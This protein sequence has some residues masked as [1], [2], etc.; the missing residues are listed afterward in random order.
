MRF[1]G[2]KFSF[3]THFQLLNFFN[4]AMPFLTRIRPAPCIGSA[5][6]LTSDCLEIPQLLSFELT[7]ER[8]LKDYL[9]I[10]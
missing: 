9:I 4:L 2:G 10:M 3:V 8:T 7:W 6:A 5:A 1:V